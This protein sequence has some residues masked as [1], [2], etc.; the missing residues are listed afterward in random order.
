M[1]IVDHIIY[2]PRIPVSL[3]EFPEQGD[4]LGAVMTPLVF[5]AGGAVDQ[6]RR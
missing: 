6:A 5:E 3:P 1:T 2:L 4:R